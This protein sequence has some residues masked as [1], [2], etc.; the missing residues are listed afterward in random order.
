MVRLLL[1][2]LPTVSALQ[3]P[4]SEAGLASRRS[5]LSL[6]AASLGA[7]LAARAETIPLPREGGALAATCMG[8]GCNSYSVRR[9]ARWLS[10]GCYPPTTNPPPALCCGPWQSQLPGPTVAGVHR[11]P[12]SAADFSAARLCC[13][14]PT[15]TAYSLWPYS[16]WPY[17]LWHYSLWLY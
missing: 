5:I 8:F 15:S 14:T 17:S 16:L 3:L 9:A 2:L 12:A 6:A 13:R 7:P 4:S 10:S 1:L 11:R